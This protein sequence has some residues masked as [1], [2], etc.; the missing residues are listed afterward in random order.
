MSSSEQT[1]SFI[2]FVIN[3]WNMEQ[4]TTRQKKEAKEDDNVT[5]QCDECCWNQ[6]QSDDAITTSTSN[7]STVVAD[8]CKRLLGREERRYDIDRRE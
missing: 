8:P 7:D 3:T 4:V 2:G 6:N 5:Q 1:N